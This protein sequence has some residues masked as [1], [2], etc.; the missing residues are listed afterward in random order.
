MNMKRWRSPAK[1]NR[2]S[3]TAIQRFLYFS[4]YFRLKL[5]TDCVQSPT[6]PIGHA[7]HQNLAKMIIVKIRR[8]CQISHII[9]VAKGMPPWK[10]RSGSLERP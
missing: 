7:K 8:G 9:V 6:A 5:N 3:I 2:K 10:R 4:G 1:I